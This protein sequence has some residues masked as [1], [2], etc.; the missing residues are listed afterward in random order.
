MLLLAIVL[1]EQLEIDAPSK[2]TVFLHQVSLLGSRSDTQRRDALA[3]LT[4]R[5][6]VTPAGGSLPVTLNSLVS[7]LCPLILDGS[8]GVRNQLLKLFQ[9][10]P[11]EEIR[12]HVAKV[13]P[14]M[15][16][17]MTH[18]SRDIRISAVEFLSVLIKVAGSDL[19]SCP[20]GWYQTLECFTT[21][22]GWR[23]ADAGKWAANKVSFGGDVKSTARIMQVLSEF[24][25]AGL[26]ADETSRPAANALAMNFPLWQTDTLMLPTKSNG[27]AYLNL[28]GSQQSDENQILDDRGDRWQVYV[29]HFQA[30]IL[31][32]IEAAKKEGGELGRTSGMLV[33]TLDL[34][35]KE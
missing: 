3:Y 7:S 33:K 34:A 4:A 26:A 20:G 1:N 21:V 2:S 6:G 14:Y 5:V 28:F 24:L 11:R 23:S 8:A 30:L 18:L 13:L 22:L 35:Q 9:A 10:L 31:A 17:A 19:V 25:Q 12:D 27:Y 29:A 15:R 32:G 16:A